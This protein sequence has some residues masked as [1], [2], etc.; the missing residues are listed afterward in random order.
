MKASHVILYVFLSILAIIVL[1]VIGRAMFIGNTIIEREVFEQS[2]QRQAGIEEAIATYEAQLAMI[3]IKLESTELTEQ[4]R[5]TLEAN[6]A[7]IRIQLQATRA[8]KGR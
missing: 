7:S 5:N 4:E 3:E 6:R 2:Y 1:W 8:Q